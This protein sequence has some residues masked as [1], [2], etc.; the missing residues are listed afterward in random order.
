MDVSF[1]FFQQTWAT[2]QLNNRVVLFATHYLLVENQATLTVCAHK[3]LKLAIK[4]IKKIA[5]HF[6][7]MA[8]H[9]QFLM[10]T[11]DFIRG[12][13]IFLNLPF[14]LKYT[15]I[16]LHNIPKDVEKQHVGGMFTQGRL[17]KNIESLT[18]VKPT[19]NAPLLSL[20][21]LGFFWGWPFFI[22]TV[23]QY[24]I[25]TDFVLFCYPF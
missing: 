15:F 22:G 23:V 7:G 14:R 24:F 21:A 8:T 20:T 3:L 13:I 25:K 19:H 9:F 18:A 16:S 17:N 10:E 11:V 12:E 1:L 2:L 6:S 5:I 4:K